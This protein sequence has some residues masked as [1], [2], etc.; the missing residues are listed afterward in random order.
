MKAKSPSGV[1]LVHCQSLH[2]AALLACRQLRQPAL[3]ADALYQLRLTLRIFRILLPLVRKD[4]ACQTLSVTL[5][6]C[7]RATSRLR[8]R[9]VGIGLIRLLEARWPRN[10]RRPSTALAQ[11]LRQQYAQFAREMAVLGLEPA[12]GQMLEAVERLEQRLPAKKLRRRASRHADDLAAQLGR[13]MQQA[14]RRQRARD[15]HRLRLAIK[16]YRFWVLALADQLP[17]VHARQV[18]ELK[19]LQVALGDCHDWDVLLHW[20]PEVPD[21]PLAAWEPVIAQFQQVDMQRAM[22]LLQPLLRRHGLVDIPDGIS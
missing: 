11:A 5:D 22:T 7:Y 4:P 8:D 13:R 3:A 9:Q 10:R 18:R 19:S 2:Q 20:L 6:L 12:L 17:D 16:H 21:A 1:L 14:L 15:W